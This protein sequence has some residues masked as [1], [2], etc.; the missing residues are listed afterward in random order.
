MVMIATT[1]GN[2]PYLPMIVLRN[3]HDRHFVIGRDPFDDM[4]E[5][6][7][8]AISVLAQLRDADRSPGFNEI[9][10]TLP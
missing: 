1:K 10:A 8:K 2:G 3:D 4:G 6:L 5:A 9:L 7:A